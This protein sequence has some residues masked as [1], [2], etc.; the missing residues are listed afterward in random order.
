[1][2]G[3]PL[4]Y[5]RWRTCVGADGARLRLVEAMSATV[6]IIRYLEE[7]LWQGGDQLIELGGPLREVLRAAVDWDGIEPFPAWALSSVQASSALLGLRSLSES[8][9]AAF[10]S[11]TVPTFAAKRDGRSP[12]TEEEEVSLLS[13]RL[14]KQAV[15][16]VL[17]VATRHGQVLAT[18]CA[19]DLSPVLARQIPSGP[20]QVANAD[21][22][23]TVDDLLVGSDLFLQV[24]VDDGTHL[25]LRLLGVHTAILAQGGG[26]SNLRALR[27]GPL[28]ARLESLVDTLVLRAAWVH[29]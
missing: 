1:M 9:V 24:R 28:G 12:A 2:A 21:L 27:D 26:Q 22:S 13:A 20:R 19:S 15:C 14:R 7:G 8:D 6:T 17:V 29:P 23:S 16:P 5:R 4:R 25:A 3:S 18:S 11:P 10:E